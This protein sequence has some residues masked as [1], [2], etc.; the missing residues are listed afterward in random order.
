MNDGL[1]ARLAV[2]DRGTL[3]RPRAKQLLNRPQSGSVSGDSIQESKS[4]S[5]L[6]TPLLHRILNLARG[7]MMGL[8]G[9]ERESKR[10]ISAFF[11]PPPP[12]NPS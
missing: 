10:R 12:C 3:A 5:D 8:Q 6:Q 7:S 2:L 11:P 4:T 1:Q 9:S